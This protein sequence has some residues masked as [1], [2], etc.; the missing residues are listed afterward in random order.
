[1]LGPSGLPCAMVKR[2]LLGALGMVN[3]WVNHSCVYTEFDDGICSYLHQRHFF[4]KIMQVT[5]TKQIDMFDL[6]FTLAFSF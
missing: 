6:L 2:P 3:P 1:M 5:C 4:S